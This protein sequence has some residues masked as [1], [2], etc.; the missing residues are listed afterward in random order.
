MSIEGELYGDHAVRLFWGPDA[1]HVPAWMYVQRQGVGTV[2]FVGASRVDVPHPL[3]YGRTLWQHGFMVGELIVRPRVLI[4]TDALRGMGLGGLAT[5]GH[6]LDEML[7]D[8]E[9][10]VGTPEMLDRLRAGSAL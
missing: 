8:G 7:E 1:R 3:W 2:S 4:G 9:L 5:H 10:I 6:D